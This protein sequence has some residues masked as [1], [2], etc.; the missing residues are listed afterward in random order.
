MVNSWPGTAMM[1]GLLLVLCSFLVPVILAEATEQEK[2]KDPFNYD[3]QTLR[4]GGLT[5][6]VVFFTLG[7]LL[8][9]SR[10]CRCS[11]NTKA[12][13][14]GDE[15][16]QAENLVASNAAPAAPEKMCKAELRLDQS[17][18]KADQMM[19]GHG[20]VCPLCSPLRCAGGGGGLLWLPKSEPVSLEKG[21]WSGCFTAGEKLPPP[22]AP[23]PF[24]PTE[25]QRRAAC[26]EMPGPREMGLCLQKAGPGSDRW[27]HQ[28]W[29]TGAE[30]VGELE[31]PQ[32]RRPQSGAGGR[33]L[34]IAPRSCSPVLSAARPERSQGTRAK[35]AGGAMGPLPSSPTDAAKNLPETERSLFSYDYETVRH[36]GLIFAVAAFLI[37]LA[38]VFSRRFR[39]GGK[40]QRRPGEVNGL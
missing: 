19:K 18:P 29:T 38:I 39:C 9:L 1:G 21:R 15:E 32:K 16:V 25:S 14:P 28:L 8:I 24:P 33:P 6:A 26:L 36:G 31:K 20:G 2:E 40:Q 10:R 13:A 35:P 22:L 27:G 4:I 17:I 11:F 37:G 34:F 5:F 12:R 7:I 23:L 30:G 3:Y